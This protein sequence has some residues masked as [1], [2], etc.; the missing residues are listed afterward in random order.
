LAILSAPFGL[1]S[2]ACSVGVFDSNRA[3]QWKTKL[4]TQRGTVVVYRI[5]G[6][7]LGSWHHVR[8]ECTILPGLL[9]VQYLYKTPE[10]GVVTKVELVD[11][12][13]VR[14]KTSYYASGPH[15]VVSLW[16][17]PCLWS[18]SS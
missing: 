14:I 12:R 18:R 5:D 2:A 9:A 8:Q 6:G 13:H 3:F 1:I 17:L 15:S 7:A 4:P 11:S 10:L 16:P